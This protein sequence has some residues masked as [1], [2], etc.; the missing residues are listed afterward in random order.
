MWPT[1]LISHRGTQVLAT[2]AISATCP[3]IRLAGNVGDMSATWQNVAYFHPDRGNLA[4]WFLVCRHTF[5]SRFSDIDV[6]R[7]DD[8][9]SS[10][11]LI[12]TLMVIY[13]TAPPNKKPKK[14]IRCLHPR[15]LRLHLLPR[16]P[17]TSHPLCLFVC[18]FVCSFG[19]LL[20]R[21]ST[22]C[23]R[24]PSRLIA[25]PCRCCATSRLLL[26]VSSSS[27]RCVLA[28]SRPCVSSRLVVV[29]RPLMQLVTHALFDC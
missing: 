7:T 12:P 27:S 20:R 24:V 21:L 5:V 23:H 22:P 13:I 14:I 2:A 8:I 25:A 9:W 26:S 19:W 4:T 1:C 15:T 17:L 18:P 3:P 29:S 16:R 11:L 6:P 28:S 10:V